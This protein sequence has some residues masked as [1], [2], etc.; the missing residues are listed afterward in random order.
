MQLTNINFIKPIKEKNTACTKKNVAT[1]ILENGKK[2]HVSSHL[3]DVTL[4]SIWVDGLSSFCLPR[5]FLARL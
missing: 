4:L 2:L 3:P 1:C 5:R